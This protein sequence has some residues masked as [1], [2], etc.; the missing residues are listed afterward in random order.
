MTGFSQ[1]EDDYGRPEMYEKQY[2]DV[3]TLV[4]VFREVNII[5]QIPGCL[6]NLTSGSEETGGACG[7]VG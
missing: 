5:W 1:Y 4:S 2:Q 7:Q 6:K 3:E